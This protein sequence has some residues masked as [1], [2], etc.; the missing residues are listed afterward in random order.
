MPSIPSSHAL[1]GGVLPGY[2]GLAAAIFAFAIA[3][4][5][6]LALPKPYPGIPH[7]KK[8]AR[9]V[10]GN[11]PEMLDYM[12]K[13]ENRIRPWY[14]E[15]Q[16]RVGSPLTQFFPT[17]FSKP[18]LLLTDF[19]E[20][21]DIQQRRTK[22]F[23]RGES[24][25]VFFRY[26]TPEFHVAL[27]QDDPRY[28]ANKAL[29]KDSMSPAYLNNLAAP[30]IYDCAMDLVNHWKFKIPLAGG[31]P[32]SA[33][34][35]IFGTISDMILA[36][37]FAF[38][39]GIRSTQQ[40]LKYLESLGS[41]VQTRHADEQGIDF[42]KLDHLPY[43]RAFEVLAEHQGEQSKVPFKVLHHYYSMLTRPELRSCYGI[44][45]QFI[46]TEI[47]KASMRLEHDSTV[48]CALDWMVI[49]EQQAAVKENRKPKYHRPAFYD[50]ISGYYAAGHETSA[51]TLSWALKYLSSHAQIQDRLR[52]ELRKSYAAA[53]QEGRTPSVEEITHTSVPY[54]NAVI[55]ET[56]RHRSPLQP[57]AREALVDTVVLGHHVPKG[58]TIIIPYLGQSL[59]TP[60]FP[61]P[62][63]LRSE[64]FRKEGGRKAW[65]DNDIQKFIPER[66]LRVDEDGKEVY[67]AAAGPMSAFG[68]GPRQC[69]GKRLAYL[70]IQ[71]VLTLLTWNLEFQP[72]DGSLGSFETMELTAT[73]PKHTYVKL[74]LVK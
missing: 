73:Q 51:T 35:D 49:R 15:Y 31:R 36:S 29:V 27:S 3:V 5:Y 19:W 42:P 8:A 56:L 28:K 9:S 13:N 66:W 53:F 69:F 7:D 74:S 54:L 63:H 62:Q 46:K 52:S 67:D 14:A 2:V 30:C 48:T 38:N 61:I 71:V 22:E 41:N 16:Q 1:L 12:A 40:Q 34:D 70:Q 23:G 68:F 43:F 39:S 32:F 21:Q 60:A 33:H 17:P 59:L 45:K 72:I 55:D 26:T 47:D 25:T 20:S 44:I 11:L 10:L 57:S 64:T 6:R 37:L 58:A 4:L 24:L 65:A 18:F 50:G